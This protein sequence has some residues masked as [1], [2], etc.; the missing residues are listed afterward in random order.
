LSVNSH[1]RKQNSVV[2]GCVVVIMIII[3][4]VAGRNYRSIYLFTPKKN[5]L[6][7]GVLAVC[8]RGE[9]SAI[10]PPYLQNPTGARLMSLRSLVCLLFWLLFVFWTEHGQ[11]IKTVEKVRG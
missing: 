5:A 10:H 6:G 1:K 11:G 4:F 2:A 9:C 8:L 3:V 7:S